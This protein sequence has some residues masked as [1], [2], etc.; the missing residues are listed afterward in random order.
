V[1]VA[2][3]QP[4][5]VTVATL[6]IATGVPKAAADKAQI[7]RVAMLYKQ[8]PDKQQPGHVRVVG[9]AAAPPPGGDPLALYNAALDRAQQIAQSLVKAGV[10]ANRVQTE[11]SPATGRQIGRVEIQF[12]P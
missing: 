9:F 10:P 1:P 2:P 5:P 7:A 12:A 11:A 4:V 3:K 6:D 8:Q